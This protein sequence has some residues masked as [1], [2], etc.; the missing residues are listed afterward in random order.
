[1]LDER[2]YQASSDALFPRAQ[3]GVVT[4]YFYQRCDQ[5]YTRSYVAAV[6][7]TYVAISFCVPILFKFISLLKN[8]LKTSAVCIVM[9]NLI[10]HKLAKKN[11][12]NLKVIGI[13]VIN[14]I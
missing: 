5:E 11:F 14:N 9:P 6:K 13:Y 2:Q 8:L 1:M 12:V 3:E 7:S 4:I 10:V